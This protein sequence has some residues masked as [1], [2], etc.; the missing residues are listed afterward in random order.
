MKNNDSF[1]LDYV[2]TIA[3]L[4]FSS[5]SFLFC[6]EG[7]VLKD[8]RRELFRKHDPEKCEAVFRKDHAESK[9][10]ERDDDSIQSHRALVEA[11][12]PERKRIGDR[13]FVKPTEPTG[14]ATVAGAHV[15]AQQ[16]RPA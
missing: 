14:R 2:E 5:G 16:H 3:L 7:A 9:K 12:R 8:Q 15:G 13:D 6:A 10:L 4:C 1:T 11:D